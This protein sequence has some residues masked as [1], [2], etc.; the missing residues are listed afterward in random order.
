MKLNN[1]LTKE[2]EEAG[3]TLDDDEDIVYLR[4]KEKVIAV[5]SATKITQPLIRVKAQ[6]YLDNWI[7]FEIVSEVQKLQAPQV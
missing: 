1:I 4:Y 7:K 2:Q 3:L 5:W 6:D